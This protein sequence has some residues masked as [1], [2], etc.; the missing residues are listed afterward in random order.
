MVKYELHVT[1]MSLHQRW[2]NKEKQRAEEGREENMRLSEFVAMRD[3]VH[4]AVV[5]ATR[6]AGG[7]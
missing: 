5:K 2:K 6:K 4:V 3:E 7:H 1:R